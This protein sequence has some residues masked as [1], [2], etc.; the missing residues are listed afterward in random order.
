MIFK[1]KCIRSEWFEGL[2]WAENLL[3]PGR[4]QENMFV[5]DVDGMEGYNILWRNRNHE[6]PWCIRQCSREF[7]RGILDYLSYKENNLK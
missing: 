3:Y 4:A 2:L 5:E 6:E 1:K 7:G